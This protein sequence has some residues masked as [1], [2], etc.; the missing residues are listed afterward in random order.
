MDSRIE[1]WPCS[2]ATLFLLL[3]FITQAH[4]AHGQ[5]TRVGQVARDFELPNRESGESVKL[6]DFTGNVILLDFFAW[7]CGPC[8]SS[9]P[10]VK[11]NIDQYYQ[12]LGGNKHGVPVTVVSI[13]VETSSPERT[14]QFISEFGLVLV[15]DD[16][17][18][19]AYSQ[20]SPEGYIPHFVILN[21]V[22]GNKDYQYMEVLY[23]DSG[24]AGAAALRT[25]I[26]K[27]RPGDPPPKITRHLKNQKIETGETAVF[28]VKAQVEEPFTYQWNFNGNVIS[29]A[30]GSELRIHNVDLE[31]QGLYVVTITDKN[32][33]SSQSRGTLLVP[34]Q[35]PAIISQ[36]KEVVTSLLAPA[37]FFAAAVGEG[38]LKLQWTFNGKPVDGENNTRLLL[39]EP[40]F[41]DS[42]DY[43]L[44]VSNANG[45]SRS[46][47]AKLTFHQKPVRQL[48]MALDNNELF[49]YST[50]YFGDKPWFSQTK[51]TSDGKDAV[52]SGSV[53]EFDYSYILTR[54]T[55][56]GTL[57]Y[58]WKI[59]GEE[60]DFLQ[61]AAFPSEV[62]NEITHSV[63]WQETSMRI[64]AGKQIIQILFQRGFTFQNGIFAAWMDQLEFT[65]D[66][67][68]RFNF[69][70][71]PAVDGFRINL[72]GVTGMSY[73]VESSTNLQE[74]SP[75]RKVTLKTDS[76]EVH[77]PVDP[78]ATE[79]FFRARATE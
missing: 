43:V 30:K 38:N 60:D 59:K 31:D 66:P 17:A 11:R 44:E 55:G 33:T 37:K 9:T 54:V 50:S 77:L 25:I 14:N 23:S 39:V 7:W 8:R 56:P 13:N 22:P 32:G 15:L 51:N 20:F 72:T 75:M 53:G 57:T 76:A 21:G 78:D 12:D 27:V 35:P 73:M 18:D 1:F 5:I 58:Y 6:S 28:S 45:T 63:D 19:K 64:P 29:G 41:E 70:G 40:W 69:V 48:A 24:Y 74:W 62:V 26:D 46:H 16:F 71:K 4:N 3:F 68:P 67:P 49:F 47:P 42:G 65:T 34:G 10:D 61:V 2:L 52:Q 36:P 79:R